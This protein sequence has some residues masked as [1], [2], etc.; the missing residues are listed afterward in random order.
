MIFDIINKD[1]RQGIFF[2]VN[3]GVITTVGLIVGISQ[4]TINPLYI[5]V[6]VLSIAISDGCGGYLECGNILTGDL[7]SDCKINIVDIVS[8]VSLISQEELLTNK[9]IL[10]K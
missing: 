7:N 9:E 5:V 4:T 6:S 2:G 10:S 3:S 8:M 1:T